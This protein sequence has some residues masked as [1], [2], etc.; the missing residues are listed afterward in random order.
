MIFSMRRD[1]IRLSPMT[2]EHQQKIKKKNQCYITKNAT[3][4]LI[5]QRLRTYIAETGLRGPSFLTNRKSCAIKMTH[6]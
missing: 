2:Y 3:K 4:N 5:T 6:I 1:D